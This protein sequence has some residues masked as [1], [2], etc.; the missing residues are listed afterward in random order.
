MQ[1]LKA[2]TSVKV[3][4]GP[5][6]DVGDGFTPETGISLSTADEAEIIKHDAAAVTSISGNT[7]AAIASADGY[8]NLTLTAAQLDTEGMLT[9]VVQDDSVCLPVMARFMVV[10]ANVFDSL[11]AAAGTDYLDINALQLAGTTQ[12]ATDL[13]DFAAAGYDPATNKVQGV[14]LVDTTTTNTDMVAA[15]PTAN[16]IADQVWDELQSAHVGAGSFGELATEIADILVDT[17]ELQSDD[18]PGLIAALNDLSAA[19]VNTE[20]DNAI[21]TYGLDHLVA[22]AVVGADVTDNSIIA[23]L[24]SKSAT[25]DWDSYVNTT[26]ALEAI[27][28]SGGGGPTAA[29][30]ADA[31]WDELQADHVTAATFGVLATEIADILADTNELQTDDYPASF[32]ALNDPTAAAIADAVW[33]EAKAGHVGVGS[34]GEEVQA[35]ALS[36]E[37]TALNDLSAAQV[38]AEVDTALADF[39]TTAAA[40]V[41]LIWDEATAGHAGAGSAGKALTDIL[42]D[43]TGLNGDA[44]RGTDSAALASVCTEARL[45]ELDA[46]NLPTDISSLNDIST[47]DVNAQVVD[48][49][50]TDTIAEMGQAIPPTTPTFEEAVMYLYMALTKAGDVDAST[51]EFYN[52]AGTVIWKKTLADDGSNYT[53]TKGASGP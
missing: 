1:Y 42:A 2:D 32:A 23:K 4:I 20:V 19:Q 40:L 45:A 37:I 28:D 36:T 26:D 29:Q 17:N 48:V 49:L 18:V 53:E 14:V 5:F 51:M 47:A 25:A 13:A 7:W 34:F 16:A 27:A 9:V 24:A 50:K 33:D 46:A 12:D 52:N 10:N 38:N 30:I 11:F 43:V 44:M 35:H 39:F 21:V 6:V 41:D 8:Y 3:V 22:A 15:A 31:V